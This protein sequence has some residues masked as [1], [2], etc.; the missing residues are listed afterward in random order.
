MKVRQLN[1]VFFSR[2]YNEPQVTTSTP[3][4]RRNLRERLR[5]ENAVRESVSE[6]STQAHPW[7]GGIA[8]FVSRMEWYLELSNALHGENQDGCAVLR[9]ELESRVVSLFTLFFHIK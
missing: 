8:N 6:H 2:R 7:G 5:A 3:P 1:F 4:L 9:A